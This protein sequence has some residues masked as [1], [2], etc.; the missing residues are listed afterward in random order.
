MAGMRIGVAFS[1]GLTPCDIVELVKL[2]ETLGYESGRCATDVAHAG[3]IARAVEHVAMGRVVRTAPPRRS[4]W[5][6]SFR[7]R[8]RRP[9]PPLVMRCV[10]RSGSTP[11]SCR[12]TT[13]C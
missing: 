9:R 5:R 11:A 2:A 13:G 10:P 7:A 1:G 12:V 4:T 6:R 8:S 3:L